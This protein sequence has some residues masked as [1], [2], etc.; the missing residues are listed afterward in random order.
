MG[1][2]T[3]FD[4]SFLQSLSVDESVWFDNYFLTNVSPLFYIET[5]ADL[6]KSVREGR[7]PED[8]VGIISKKFPEMHGTPCGYHTHQCIGDLLGYSAPMT[9][10]IPVAGGRRVRT[11]GKRGAVFE[12]S[13]EAEA[14]SRWNRGEFLEVERQYARGWRRMLSTLDLTKVSEGIRSLGIDAAQC[15]S[16]EEAKYMASSLVSGK[17]KLYELL[18]LALIFMGVPRDTHRNIMRRWRQAGGP[19]LVDY[20][21]YA[22]FVFEVELFFQIAV[23]SSLIASERSSNR[24]D[25][26]YMFYLP[27]CMMFVSSD[28][29]HQRCAPLFLRTDQEFVWGPELKAGLHE[30]N[31]HFLL[32]P[33]NIREEGIMSFAIDPPRVGSEIV[34]R[35][36]ER[37]LPK[38]SGDGRKASLT[39]NDED[40]T[41]RIKEMVNAPLLA[42]TEAD[43]GSSDIDQVV[44]KRS[45]RRRKGSW[46]QIPKALD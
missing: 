40:I 12:R 34:H 10:Q 27:F 38:Y 15:K 35:L 4:K 28:K 33:E 7:T 11:G 9:G 13:P 24:V 19:S 3:L 21:P 39:S 14:F 42:P 36:W 17:K 44:L 46:Y 1:P 2:I 20:A 45:V 6:E 16:L 18:N 37:L 32:L 5:L 30:I 23:G 22:A 8:E 25:I 41:E 31:E 26:S 43:F 29:L